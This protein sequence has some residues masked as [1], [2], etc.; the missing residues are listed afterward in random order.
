MKKQQKP[1]FPL[2]YKGN[3]K[4]YKNHKKYKNNLVFFIFYKLYLQN[5]IKKIDLDFIRL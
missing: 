1:P 2:R 5:I 3:T 4:I